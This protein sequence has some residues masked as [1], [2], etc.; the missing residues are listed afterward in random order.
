MADDALA[1]VGVLVTR[2][3]A[4]AERLVNAIAERGGTAIEFPVIEIRARDAAE[5]ARQTGE[6]A[7]PDV[8]IFVSANAARFGLASAGDAK[9]A[10]IG[11]GTARFVEKCGH[12]VDIRS[13]DGFDSEH[14]LATAELQDVADKVVRI[15]RG[16]GGRELLAATLRERGAT[17]EYLEV[18]SRRV[19]EYA[20][21]DIADIEKQLLAGD[22][23]I[24]TIMSVKSLVNLI[25]LLPSTCLEAIKSTPLVTPAARVIKEAEK[26]IPGIQTILADGPQARDMVA[27]IVTCTN[28]GHPDD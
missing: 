20:P 6:L 10:V 27:A 3:R 15:I 7:E 19:P 12:T 16:N 28:P 8:V 22:V 5:I 18:Y 4:Q 23:D 26:R 21:A 13:P 24:I 9:I 11:P 1:G 17:V 14:L 2:P 25:A